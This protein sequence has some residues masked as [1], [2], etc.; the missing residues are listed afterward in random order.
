MNP[1]E[2]RLPTL[3]PPRPVRQ[4]A[5]PN[6]NNDDIDLLPSFILQIN[7]ELSDL[8]APL[9]GH[10]GDI[11]VRVEFGRIILKDI[12]RKAI[13]KPGSNKSYGVEELLQILEPIDS[14]IE[15]YFTSIL[16]S[17]P[18]DIQFIMEMKNHSGQRIWNTESKYATSRV[19]YEFICHRQNALSY[20]PTSL[21]VNANSV[22]CHCRL[23]QKREYGQIYVHG[24]KRQWD[25]RIAADGYEMEKNIDP[26]YKRLGNEIT[27]SLYV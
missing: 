24:T 16:T 13:A 17:V 3:S 18:S 1:F 21:E 27:D 10:R 25:L 22:G 11:K 23:R 12:P 6:L 19:M 9:R 7:S 2:G 14:A 4:T 20:L 8:I 5:R 26:I 15:T